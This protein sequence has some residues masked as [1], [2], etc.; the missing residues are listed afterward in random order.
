MNSLLFYIAKIQRKLLFPAIRESHIHSK[1]SVASGC[2]INYL[3]MNKYSYIG[4]NT[5]V[6]KAKIGAFCSI[7]NNCQIGAPSHQLSYVSTSPVFCQ[8][9]NTLKTNFS[10]LEAPCDAFVN[11]GNDVWIGASV[12]IKNGVTISDGAVIGMG[13]IVTKDVGPY[14]IWV[15]NPAR[16]V[17]DRFPEDIKREL[18]KIKWWEYEDNQLVK[19]ANTFSDPKEFLKIIK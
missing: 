14:E 6:Y 15:G 8:N 2:D 11:I 12:I 7:A 3:T 5:Y 17:R 9:R 16:K 1:S 19:V 4:R 13:S 10:T 18:L